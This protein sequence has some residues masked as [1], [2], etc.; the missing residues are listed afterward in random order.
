MQKKY[1]VSPDT[2]D[3]KKTCQEYDLPQE[4]THLSQEYAHNGVYYALVNHAGQNFRVGATTPHWRK[5][6][7]NVT[8]DIQDFFE[9]KEQGL[10]LAPQ[11]KI[12]LCPQAPKVAITCSG[13]GAIRPGMG[14][15]LYD[16][17]PAVREAM[18]H[19]DAIAEWDVLSLLDETDME[20]IQRFR[21][22]LPYLFFLEYAQ[23]YHLQTLG[24]APHVFSGH[25]LGELISLC[26]AGI[27]SPEE[28][29]IAMETRAKLMDN[30]ENDPSYDMGMMA[31]YAPLET[32]QNVL[33]LFPE[34]HISNHNSPSQCL[35]GGK[36]EYLSEAR[37]A[38]RKQKRP[39]MILP[40]NMAF[41][42][43]HMRSLRET[44]L[45][46]L[47]K[48]SLMEQQNPV[49]SNVTASIYPKD[50][51]GI[52]QYIVDLDENT[53]R[54]VDCVHTM[55]HTYGVRHFVELG[56]GDV[57]TNLT[58]EI[59]PQAVCLA[60]AEKND[61][62]GGMRAA[63]AQLY[64]LGHLPLKKIIAVSSLYNDAT[65]P[66]DEGHTEK[67]KALDERDLKHTVEHE[68]ASAVK[69]DAEEVALPTYIQDIIPIL[70]E[71]T[72]IVAQDIRA[73]MDLRHDLGVRSVR[74]PAMLYA[75]EQKFGIQVQ[76]EDVMHVST[77]QDLA[78]VVLELRQRKEGDVPSVILPKE[79]AS[80]I[81]TS[82][83]PSKHA[84]P[85]ERLLFM[86]S[87]AYIR[88][89]WK[90]F[91]SEG[92]QIRATSLLVV[93]R[94]EA[95]LAQETE[96][97]TFPLWAINSIAALPLVQEAPVSPQN[98]VFTEGLFLE[99]MPEFCSQLK[100]MRDE[101][102][103]LCAW[104]ALAQLNEKFWERPQAECII[105]PVQ[106][107]FSPYHV[108]L[109]LEQQDKESLANN[110]AIYSLYSAVQGGFSWLQPCG[111]DGLSLQEI[112]YC[113]ENCVKGVTREMYGY[114]LGARPDEAIS[115]EAM[116][117]LQDAASAR[118]TLYIRT[119]TNNGRR[120]NHA[121]KWATAQVLLQ[122]RGTQEVLHPL[123]QEQEGKNFCHQSK[124]FAKE[125]GLWHSP[126]SNLGHALAQCVHYVQNVAQ[127]N[128]L[129][130]KNIDEN[131]CIAH[132][133]SIASIARIRH[134]ADV[135]KNLH[136]PVYSCWRLYSQ[137]AD[138]TLMADVHIYDAQN[139]LLVTLEKIS[140]AKK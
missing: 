26:L 103:V 73:H 70:V 140:F 18:E 21:W 35:V 105:Y 39:A 77:V 62:V 108:S 110:E 28:G 74:F 82:T 112:P 86:L 59:M 43:P 139:V 131:I 37:K 38:F 47:R 48:F 133:D 137:E 65:F 6:L 107:H 36:K 11:Q 25:S 33:Q 132:V 95:S 97:M 100:K 14:R 69:K 90:E 34:L 40:I 10:W 78:K 114:V 92:K 5:E 129:T 94:Q 12:E 93:G 50:K 88:Q 136:G 72:G 98:L 124:E 71:N 7:T 119:I 1:F 91:L 128:A 96:D 24:F 56:S 109:P 104:S 44:S 111:L 61:E 19:L 29:W 120:T 67:A 122:E 8:P 102:Q 15:A 53:V 22:Q 32:V 2:Q 27:F 13:V 46:S 106:R 118:C 49:M 99:D 89:A 66:K 16:T 3:M 41:H 127:K 42:H 135:T 9:A 79:Q 75:F 121:Q 134:R 30:L 64:A 84:S 55:W 87:P 31:V 45:D 17:F 125:E 130:F 23:A 126:P 63:M 76:F 51:E 138:K 117:P 113:T 57:V 52:C 68:I 60:V 85:L 4:Y 58:K 123:W 116:S 80:D 81:S 115:D 54:W 83:L 20:K 101:K